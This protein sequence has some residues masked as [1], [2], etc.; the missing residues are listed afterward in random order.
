MFISLSVPQI[1]V[2]IWRAHTQRIT[3]LVFIDIEM[4]KHDNVTLFN[5]I[6]CC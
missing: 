3:Q 5:T 2:A 6:D 4:A 1:G